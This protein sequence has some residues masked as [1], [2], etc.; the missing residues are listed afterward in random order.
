MANEL[1][2]PDDGALD[3]LSL[4]AMVIRLDSGTV[5]FGKASEAAIHVSGGEYNVGPLAAGSA[6]DFTKLVTAIAA[7]APEPS[8]SFPT[9]GALAERWR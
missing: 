8:P 1:G 4:G 7:N 6:F 9:T 2:V 3:F 5:P